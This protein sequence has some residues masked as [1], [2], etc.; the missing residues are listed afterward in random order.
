MPILWFLTL[1][2]NIFLSVKT[3]GRITS[4][5][6][7][8]KPLFG[9]SVSMVG[10][11]FSDLL[12]RLIDIGHFVLF[13]HEYK[14]IFI[15]GAAFFFLLFIECYV[16]K[17]KN[18]N[19]YLAIRIIVPCVF[20]L[21]IITDRWHHLFRKS[22]TFSG[23]LSNRFITENGPLYYLVLLYIYLNIIYIVFLLIRYIIS[24]SKIYQIQAIFLIVCI[25]ITFSANLVFQLA[26][27][28]LHSRHIIDF[29]SLTFGLT[30]WQLYYSMFLR[31]PPKVTKT[32]IDSL[33][34]Q[35]EDI[36][37]LLDQNHYVIY[38][39]RSTEKLFDQN[40][41]ELQKAP[42]TS[43]TSYVNEKILEVLQNPGPIKCRV[44][45]DQIYVYQLESSTLLDKKS[46]L[47]GYLIRGSDITEQETKRIHETI[48]QD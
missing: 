29:T 31:K 11:I 46:R 9:L 16:E 28:W 17:Q 38:S 34:D 8:V 27:V 4:S 37:L 21:I 25:L 2:V 24:V 30:A 19:H 26:Q 12:I 33:K 23:G 5:N 7:F 40:I 13:L 44:I 10:W 14:Y 15:L 42:L 39:N 6:H 35:K 32:I 41:K 20:F 22:L 36:L 45:R 3:F 1:I 18:T 43:L 47:I 48:H